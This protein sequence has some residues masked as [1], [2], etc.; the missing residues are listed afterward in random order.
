MREDQVIAFGMLATERLE[1]FGIK[2]IGGHLHSP[3]ATTFP[4]RH[5]P[6]HFVPRHFQFRS[7]S[8]IVPTFLDP[9]SSEQ[10][11]SI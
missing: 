1:I 2:I 5:I 10:V 11:R 3:D 7:G 4:F 8:G 9:D 6:H